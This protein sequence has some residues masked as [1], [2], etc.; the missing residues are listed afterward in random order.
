MTPT[1]GFSSH[2]AVS[3]SLN[4][5]V[6]IPTFNR[7]R[8]CS[9][10]QLRSQKSIFLLESSKYLLSTMDQQTQRIPCSRLRDCLR[11]STIGATYMNRCQ[12]CFP[13]GTGGPREPRRHLRVYITEAELK[14]SRFSEAQII[15]ILREPEAGSPVR[16]VCAA[17]S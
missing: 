4:I 8:H 17:A 7:A 1:S 14:R 13:P 10:Q 12:A 6:I 16:T 11:Q 3:R 15:G 2:T 5:S 9:G